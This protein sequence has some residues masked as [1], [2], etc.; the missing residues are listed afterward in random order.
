MKTAHTVR[1]TK[2]CVVPVETIGEV[3]AALQRIIMFSKYNKNKVGYFAVLYHITT[4][5]IRDYI[6]EGRFENGRRMERVAVLFARRYL[7]AWELWNKGEQITDSWKVTFET[8]ENPETIVLQDLLLGINA[9]INL[10]LGI[11][12]IETMKGNELNDWKNDFRKMQEIMAS[13]TTTVQ[14]RLMKINPLTPLLGM[15]LLDP[16]EIMVQ[17]RIKKAREGAWQ[18]AERLSR[19]KGKELDHFIFRRDKQVAALGYNISN[20]SLL[21]RLTLC[22]VRLFERRDVERNICILQGVAA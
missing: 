6:E 5:R 12:A 19:K 1:N 14:N 4:S 20:P 7:E 8:G 21:M 13:V 17:F 3:L 2:G 18:F 9:H 22:I 11:A 10:D 16:N 15:H